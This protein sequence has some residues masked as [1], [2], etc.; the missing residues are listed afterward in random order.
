M[1]IIRLL[2]VARHGRGHKQV[3]EVSTLVTF[4]DQDRYVPTLVQVDI[5]EQKKTNKGTPCTAHLGNKQPNS[6]TT[7][8]QR[9]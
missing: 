7:R 9:I 1:S 8:Q 6:G 3:F 5:R 2:S 4:E